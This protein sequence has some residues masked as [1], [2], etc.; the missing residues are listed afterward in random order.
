[1]KVVL[2][3]YQGF[4]GHHIGAALMRAGHDVLG[5]DD[6]RSGRKLA[7]LGYAREY[8]S[9]FADFDLRGDGA[10]DVHAIVHC[11][12]TADV[13]RNWDSR[14]ERD[15]IW[16]NNVE[17]T[18]VML[19]NGCD[20]ARAAHVVFISTLAVNAVEISPYAASKL[21]GEALVRCYAKYSHILR[22]AAVVGEGYHHGHV[23]DF[24]RMAKSGGIVA[25]SSGTPIR[26]YVHALDV[27]DAVVQALEENFSSCRELSG[28]HWTPRDTVR[29]MNVEATWAKEDFGWRGDV[30][31]CAPRNC[32]REIG[33]GVHDALKSLGWPPEM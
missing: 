17:N 28:G 32:P 11:A 23:A 18:R 16:A 13:S 4:I 22:L 19:E 25:K 3:G 5:V 30:A 15:D 31:V 9:N 1:V 33:D 27:A 10:I 24:V 14:K 21:A 20:A 8:V 6:R 26:S 7:G 12:A 29:V 2:T